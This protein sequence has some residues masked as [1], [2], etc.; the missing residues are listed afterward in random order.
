MSSGAGEGAAL[1]FGLI[2]AELGTG[3]CCVA[4]AANSAR[5]AMECNATFSA[6]RSVPRA[7]WTTV[8]LLVIE[9]LFEP[10]KLLP[11]IELASP[12]MVMNTQ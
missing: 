10:L 9:P 8:P 12:V 1:S 6:T 3:A 7:Q 2:A 11:L 5:A 4:G